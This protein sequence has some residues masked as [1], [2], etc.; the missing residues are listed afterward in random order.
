MSKKIIVGAVLAA[1]AFTSGIST[2]YADTF[3]CKCD[4]GFAAKGVAQVKEKKP[5]LNLDCRTTWTSGKPA[6]ET[7]TGDYSGLVKAT[8]PEALPPDSVTS[9][10]IRP[11]RT[12]QCV[13]GLYDEVNKHQ[14]W[15]G[16]NCDT[17]KN[18]SRDGFNIVAVDPSDSENTTRK[19][20]GKA[21]LSTKNNAFLAFYNDNAAAGMGKGYTLLAACVEPK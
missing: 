16:I 14:E 10:R 15:G 5:D 13:M 18:T 9:I 17:S 11:R 20:A 6:N 3:A 8:F 1:A 12:D 21:V 7:D 19:M 4:A 2:A